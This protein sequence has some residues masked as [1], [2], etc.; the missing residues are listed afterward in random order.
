VLAGERRESVSK[1]HRVG[2][3]L[4]S[5]PLL[6]SGSLAGQ[7]QS[8]TARSEK[9]EIGSLL[10]ITIPTPDFNADPKKNEVLFT[11]VDARIPAEFVSSDLKTVKARVPKGAKDGAVVVFVEGRE[12]G[13]T[14]IKVAAAAASDGS[15]CKEP[16]IAFKWVAPTSLYL[17]AQTETSGTF[18]VSAWVL[19]VNPP[20]GGLGLP[21]I[22]KVAEASAEGRRFFH[23]TLPLSAGENEIPVTD[24]DDKKLCSLYAADG[25]V[26]V[27]YSGVGSATCPGA[28]HGA[29][30]VQALEKHVLAIDIGSTF[31]LEKGGNWSSQPE[32]ALTATSRWEPYLTGVVDLRY[33][34]VGAIEESATKDEA[35]EA[36]P[37][38]DKEFNPF[39]SGGGVFRGDFYMAIIPYPSRVSGWGIFGGAGFTT[40]PKTAGDEG[41]ETRLRAF[42]GLRWQVFGYNAGRPADSLANTRGH[43]QVAYAQ[44]DLWKWDQR[45]VDESGAESFVHRDER[46]RYLIQGQI[47]LPEIGGEYLRIAVRLDT[48]VPTSNEGPSDV[49]ISALATLDPK[50]FRALFGGVGKVK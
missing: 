9:V 48:S 38:E 50:I 26:Q 1:N 45:V 3:L 6:L 29:A 15:Q 47:E 24:L 28:V 8:V 33:T 25:W 13:R 23:A 22:C 42:V 40:V 30:R 37:Q 49:R 10:E 39:E 32:V 35:P 21:S 19:P 5:L 27:E 31:L 41:V 4:L 36:E 44:D 16:K 7:G 2:I 20:Y 46:H 14:E 11:G 43:F 34:S 18:E 12:H 17:I